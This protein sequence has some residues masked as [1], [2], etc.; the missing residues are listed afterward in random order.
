MNVTH[1]LIAI[2]ALMFCVFLAH[3]PSRR[4]GKFASS[5]AAADIRGGALAALCAC[6]CD[7][8][9]GLDL[10]ICAWLVDLAVL[11]GPSAD[12]ARRSLAAR[13]FGSVTGRPDGRR[14]GGSST[15]SA[16]RRTG[17]ASMRCAHSGNTIRLGL[18]GSRH[19]KSAG[20]DMARRSR[21][22]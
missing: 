17:I 2:L 1:S 12:V 16:R 14:R 20:A 5:L 22:R 7:Y 18:M 4:S 10:C 8:D 6:A 11:C 15:R 9:D 21:M 13:R 3:H 19:R